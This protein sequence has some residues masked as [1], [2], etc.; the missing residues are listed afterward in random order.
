MNNVIKGTNILNAA[1][2]FRQKPGALRENTGTLYFQLLFLRE[3]FGA[4]GPLH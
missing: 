2:L 1:G 4:C 3:E